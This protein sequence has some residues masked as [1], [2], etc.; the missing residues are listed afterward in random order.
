MLLQV[1][2]LTLSRLHVRF[3]TAKPMLYV[4]VHHVELAFE[5]TSLKSFFRSVARSADRRPQ[6]SEDL[7]ARR[8]VS[9]RTAFA[10]SEASQCTDPTRAFTLTRNTAL[11][12]VYLSSIPLSTTKIRFHH[13]L[14]LLEG[15]QP[16]QC[17][18][19]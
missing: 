16:F 18:V 5:C 12:L 2:A 9:L 6:N 19:S 13:G 7:L 4:D 17:I 11:L 3:Y 10:P 15:L 8:A 14:Y 1:I